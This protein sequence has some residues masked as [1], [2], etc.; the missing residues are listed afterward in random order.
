M[1][2]AYKHEGPRP[3]AASGF[4]SAGVFRKRA[5]ACLWS[6]ALF[7]VALTPLRADEATA[8]RRFEGAKASEAQLIAFVK[9]MP[10]GAD[11]HNHV[12]GAVYA[13][14]TLDAAIQSSLFFDPASCT[15]SAQPSPGA[16][17]AKELLTNQELANK[18]LDAASMRGWHPAAESGEDHFFAAWSH[19]NVPLSATTSLLEVLSRAKAQNISYLELMITPAPSDA[20]KAAVANPPAVED[21]EQAF[22]AM[23]GRLP[24]L[25]AATRAHLDQQE[26][27]L[28]KGELAQAPLTGV[29][30]PINFRY[31]FTVNRNLPNAD[32]FAHMACG[33][34][35]V[36]G[37]RRVAGVNILSPEDHVMARH[38][39]D[40]QMKLIDFLWRRLGQPNLS[41][42]A[43]ELTL[44]QSPVEVLRNRIR[45]TIELGHARRIGHGVSIAWEDDLPGL[46]QE[47]KDKRVEVEIC[48]TSNDAILGVSGDRH[49]FNLYREAQ[50]AVNLNTDDE[51]VGR[52]N[53]TMEFVRAIRSY[54]LSYK[55]VKR[56][57]RNSLEYSFLPGA[58]LYRGGDYA[59]V[60]PEFA[61][62]RKAG[63]VPSPGGRALLAASEKLTLEV[64]LERAFVGFEE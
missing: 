19:L 63:W 55:E 39:F 60:R 30:G 35:L 3:A 29:G 6:V 49:P 34:A 5:L 28:A 45:K 7:L 17:P 54:H 24:A 47:M 31:I 36:Q 41:L 37:D 11:L 32:F 43:G 4:P 57:I 59:K 13:E 26:L 14:T 52:T 62:V 33:M 16:V 50:V 18:M 21:L 53:L 9:R 12:S 40:T 15:F 1:A 27:E 61:G 42:H 20:L 25:I 23:Q 10:K 22:L 58:S 2:N 64:R 8:T 44:A 38:D 51:G 56:L 46:L 48:L